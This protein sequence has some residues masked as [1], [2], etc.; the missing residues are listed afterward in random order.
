MPARTVSTG[1]RP[2]TRRQV[3]L[4]SSPSRMNGEWFDL[5]ALKTPSERSSPSTSC[6]SPVTSVQSSPAPNV[7]AHSRS[8]S[9]VSFTGSTLTEMSRAPRPFSARASFPNVAPIGGQTP[10]HV[11]KTKLI[12]TT[13]PRTRSVWKRTGRPSWSISGVSGTSSGPDV[14]TASGEGVDVAGAVEPASAP[15]LTRE[16]DVSVFGPAGRR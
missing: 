2:W 5:S 8:R 15:V 3:P 16:G 11:V 9:G 12:A 6:F 10:R 13:R 7:P 1:E 14:S 4:R